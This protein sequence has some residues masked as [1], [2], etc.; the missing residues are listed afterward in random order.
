MRKQTT[1]LGQQTTS[2]SQAARIIREYLGDNLM[3]LSISN[4][5]RTIYADLTYRDFKPERVVRRH[6][7]DLIPNLD[8]T[9]CD[10]DYTDTIIVDALYADL[11]VLYVREPDGT[12][13]PTTAA[14]YIQE[15]LRHRDLSPDAPQQPAWANLTPEQREALI[16]QT[17]QQ[18]DILQ[19]SGAVKPTGNADDNQNENKAE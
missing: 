16:R 8:F 14:D 5:G 13:H 17:A 15:L 2:E 3:H 11:T 10:R 6:L 4:H 18:H 7:E 9:S 19:S 1:T 12:L